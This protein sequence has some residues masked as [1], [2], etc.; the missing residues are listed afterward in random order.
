MKLSFV[1]NLHRYICLVNVKNVQSVCCSF[2]FLRG[3]FSVSPFSSSVCSAFSSCFLCV[4]YCGRPSL[5][6][7]PA[8]PSWGPLGR[9]VGV[10][11]GPL[12]LPQ[13]VFNVSNTFLYVFLYNSD[14]E[15]FLGNTALTP[16]SPN[17][18]GSCPFLDRFLHVF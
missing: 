16:L 2:R 3:R 17:L 5:G 1:R 11:S 7:C 9:L 6:S 10:V 15:T 12:P 13:R 8:G 14:A 18:P 4:F